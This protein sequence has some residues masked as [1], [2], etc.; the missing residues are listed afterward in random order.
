MLNEIKLIYWGAFG[1][2][3]ALPILVLTV[4]KVFKEDITLFGLFILTLVSIIPG[5]GFLLTI[6]I[7]LVAIVYSL[8]KSNFAAI[9]VIKA[10]K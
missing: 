1:L 2:V 8:A 3:V 9:V 10:K 7:I 4:N 5:V 6:V